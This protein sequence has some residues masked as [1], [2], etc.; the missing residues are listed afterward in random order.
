M[1]VLSSPLLP[2]LILVALGSY[3]HVDS[4]LQY[5]CSRP[6]IRLRIVLSEK[7]VRLVEFQVFVCLLQF[8]S[9]RLD[10]AADPTSGNMTRK[11]R[12][13]PLSFLEGNVDIDQV[14]GA[15]E[16]IFE[17]WREAFGGW[18]RLV[19]T[20]INSINDD[21]LELGQGFDKVKVLVGDTDHRQQ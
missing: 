6:K 18:L 15:P 13:S 10:L 7:F 12:L 14:F 8:D 2:L 9:V 1:D 16:K 11:A 20:A 17:V 5:T 19:V 3:V 21:P 4:F